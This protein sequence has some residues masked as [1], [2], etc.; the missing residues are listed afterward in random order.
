[1]RQSLASSASVRANANVAQPDSATDTRLYGRWLV[2]AR[3][4]WI[5]LAFA[6]VALN[7]IALPST[8]L[9]PLPP[10]AIRALNRIGFSPDLY[11]AIGN[12]ES[13]MDFL[14]FL[15]MAVL[16]FWRRSEDR[17]ALFG[18]IMLLTFGGIVAGGIFSPNTGGVVPPLASPPAL[19][20]VASLLVVI[21]QSSLIGFFFVFPSGHFVPRWTRWLSLLMVVYWVVVM[22]DP[23]TFIGPLGFMTMVFFAAALIAQV[24]RY[25][26]VSTPRQREQTKW[27]VLGIVLCA[28]IIILP[29]VIVG[30]LPQ[31]AQNA[32][33][34][35]SVAGNLLLSG[36]WS[37]ALL[38]I[39]VSIAVAILSSR[40]WDIDVIINKTLVYGS[41]TALLVGIYIGMVVGMETLVRNF[42]GQTDSPPAIIV[43]ST[44]VIAVLFQ[45]LRRGIQRVIDRRFYRSKY[46]SA[47]TLAT[48]GATLRM[49]TDLEELSERLIIAVQE[50]MQP[51]HASLW[52][53][54]V[55]RRT[56][57][58]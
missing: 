17:M 26:R 51:A 22:I 13:L 56:P 30:L 11:N 23:A 2:A 4:A 7:G 44:L 10:D 6:V 1:M 42:T 34:S 14:A 9:A 40:L 38:L 55:D 20:I 21:A 27:V 18:S 45:P 37:V 39:P 29:Q 58:Q 43:V 8:L 12:A 52:L 48:F 47:R 41:L 5:S 31:E 15:A 33:Y 32:L 24:Y 53:R 35:S 28:L 25:R 50:T 36:R 54:T 16:L 46:D 49:E 19:R 57:N 3:I